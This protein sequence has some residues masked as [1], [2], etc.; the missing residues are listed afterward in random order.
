MSGCCYDEET[1]HCGMCHHFYVQ[2]GVDIAC[3]GA[4][5]YEGNC[6]HGLCTM[7]QCRALCSASS[8]C[9]YFAS[10][11]SGHCETYASCS[12]TETDDGRAIALFQREQGMCSAGH[13]DRQG[14][15]S[16]DR[17][18]A[19]SGCCYDEETDHCG[20]CQCADNDSIAADLATWWLGLT[21]ASGCQDLLSYCEQYPYRARTVCPVTCGVC[22]PSCVD[23]HA[24][25]IAR[26]AE[27]GFNIPR[28]RRRFCNHR[29]WGSEVRFY[30]PVTCDQ[31]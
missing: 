5:I 11:N 6:N 29:R 23:D 1:D 31:C 13:D 25:L 9:E 17:C 26:A 27:L 2:I 18:T 24:G 4:A 10:W 20:M 21:G 14:A 16:E 7:D 28:C 3:T 19:M 22:D 30:C 15:T 12:E 8:A